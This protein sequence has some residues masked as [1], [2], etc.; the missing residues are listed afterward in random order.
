M[1]ENSYKY[2]DNKTV[3]TCWNFNKLKYIYTEHA[4]LTLYNSLFVS[5]IN[6]DL[7]VWSTKLEPIFKI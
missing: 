6:Y 7:L 5:Q 1:L 3:Q 2:A 4:L